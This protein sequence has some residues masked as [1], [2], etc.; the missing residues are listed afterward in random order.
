MFLNIRAPSPIPALVSVCIAP[1]FLPAFAI[2]F[3]IQEVE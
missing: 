1:V 3:R 2:L